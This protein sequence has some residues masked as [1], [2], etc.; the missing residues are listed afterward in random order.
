MLN[1]IKSNFILKTVFE[2]INR[3]RKL[4]IILYNK[5]IMNRCNL[6]IDDFKEY[7]LFKIFNEKYNLNIKSTDIK[8]L[9]LS[10]KYIGDKLLKYLSLIKFHELKKLNIGCNDITRI[11]LLERRNNK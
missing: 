2:H 8:E 10:W 4:K 3:K 5:T 1:N 7:K 6:T 9:D 11:N